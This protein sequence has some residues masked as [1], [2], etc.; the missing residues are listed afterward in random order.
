MAC[1][2]QSRRTAIVS[3]H[4]RMDDTPEAFGTAHKGVVV[5]ATFERYDMS[6][7]YERGT[8]NI[9]HYHNY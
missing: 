9:N 1:F 4:F 8:I 7:G 6:C 2:R 3:K 5:K